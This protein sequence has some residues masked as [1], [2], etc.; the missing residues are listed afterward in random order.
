MNESD[1]VKIAEFE[2]NKIQINYQLSVVA[3]KLTRLKQFIDDL[4]SWENNIRSM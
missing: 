3:Y 2:I 1:R 4:S